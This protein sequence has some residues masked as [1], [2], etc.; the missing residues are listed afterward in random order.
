MQSLPVTSN[1]AVVKIT[2]KGQTTI[3]REV[4]DALHVVPG[5]LITWEISADGTAVVRRAQPLDLDYLRSLEGTL[6]EWNSA[7]DEEAYRDL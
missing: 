3:P 6:S 5:D 4:R 1:L 2:S 7:E